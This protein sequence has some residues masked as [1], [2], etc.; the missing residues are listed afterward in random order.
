MLT[1]VLRPNLT[2][3]QLST[4]LSLPPLILFC[5]IFWPHTLPP[6]RVLLLPNPCSPE[7]NARHSLLTSLDTLSL[8]ERTP[9]CD[10]SHHSHADD[11]KSTSLLPIFFLRPKPCTQQLTQHLCSNIPKAPYTERIQTWALCH[12]STPPFLFF[13]SDIGSPSKKPHI[14][15]PSTLLP[16]TPTSLPTSN[17]ILSLVDSIKYLSSPP[18]SLHLHCQH[19]TLVTIVSYTDNCNSLVTG[20]TASRVENGMLHLFYSL[21]FS[22]SDLSKTQIWLPTCP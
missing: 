5:Q 17:Q 22:Q 4:L 12:N 6:F 16:T 11:S 10:S 8:A 18:I 3:R 1:D 14:S 2:S 21:H 13:N 19:P 7:C 9:L 20:L 15:L